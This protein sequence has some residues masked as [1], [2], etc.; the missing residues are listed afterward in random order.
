MEESLSRCVEFRTDYKVLFAI[1]VILYWV[2]LLIVESQKK[3]YIEPRQILWCDNAVHLRPTSVYKLKIF[4]FQLLSVESM[5][6]WTDGFKGIY[7]YVRSDENC[8]NIMKVKE[9]KIWTPED[10]YL[11]ITLIEMRITK[12]FYICIGS[13]ELQWQET[14]NIWFEK[15]QLGI[16]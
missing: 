16:L 11:H 12:V 1:S 13:A 6:H 3:L 5:S 10:E 2:L 7:D 9:L 8:P 14:C 15:M 4:H